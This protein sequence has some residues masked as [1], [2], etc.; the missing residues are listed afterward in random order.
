MLGWYS[1]D[2][3]WPSIGYQGPLIARR[4]ATS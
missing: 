2:A 1:Q 3:S 4:A